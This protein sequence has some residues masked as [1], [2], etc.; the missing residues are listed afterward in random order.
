MAVSLSFFDKFIIEKLSDYF[1][2]DC[3]YSS[4]A[5]SKPQIWAHLRLLAVFLLYNR[6]DMDQ[7]ACAPVI[8][9]LPV[10]ESMPSPNCYLLDNYTP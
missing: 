3:I 1:F 10:N 8:H 9:A 2:L 5:R 4:G 6:A 7:G